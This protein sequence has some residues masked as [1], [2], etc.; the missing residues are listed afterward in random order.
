MLLGPLLGL[1]A[2]CGTGGTAGADPGARPP[3]TGTPAAEASF[4]WNGLRFTVRRLPSRPDR[5]RAE[6]TVTSTVSRSGTWTV[7]ACL[8][9]L[10]LYRDGHL[11]WDRAREGLCVDGARLLQLAPGESSTFRGSVR[12]SDLRDADLPEDLYEVRAYFPA[13]AVPGPP[14]AAAELR[15]GR[16]R[17]VPAGS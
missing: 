13:L 14:R 1:A 3:E 8:V 9:R 6:T 2:A 5:V 11:V 17:L 7:P 4:E 15:L 12:P 10:R 16:T